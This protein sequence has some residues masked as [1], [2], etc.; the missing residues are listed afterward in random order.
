MGFAMRNAYLGL[1]RESDL[2]LMRGDLKNCV[3]PCFK[4]HLKDNVKQAPFKLPEAIHQLAL[5]TPMQQ[6]KVAES[7]N[8]QATRAPGCK[9]QPFQ[10]FELSYNEMC[11]ARM[12]GYLKNNCAQN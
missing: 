1:F 7:N 4:A 10:V 3:C 11:K 5:L 8:L 6:G 2:S 12:P 9:E